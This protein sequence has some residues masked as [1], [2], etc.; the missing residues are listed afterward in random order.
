[1]DEYFDQAASDWNRLGYRHKRAQAV[2]DQLRRQIVILPGMKALE[3]GCGTGLLGF[4]LI[5]D[6]EF[7]TF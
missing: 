2:A 4:P 7:V 5:A 1:M 6:F 3:F